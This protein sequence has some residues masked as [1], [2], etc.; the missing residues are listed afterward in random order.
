M[1]QS[2]RNSTETSSARWCEVFRNLDPNSNPKPLD[3]I[4]NPNP[5]PNPPGQARPDADLSKEGAALI[6]VVTKLIANHAG[7]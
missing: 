6:E 2:V 3:T 4:S 7:G 1:L 5:N